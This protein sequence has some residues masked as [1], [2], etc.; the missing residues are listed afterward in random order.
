MLDIAAFANTFGEN[1]SQVVYA[2]S[3]EQ[4]L[5]SSEPTAYQ[6]AFYVTDNTLEIG[7]NQ[8]VAV[9]N[10]V[11]IDNVFLTYYGSDN[12]VNEM[13]DL[14]LRQ[15]LIDEIKKAVSLGAN[16]ADAQAIA[17]QDDLT[18][19]AIEEAVKELKVKEF[20]A[21]VTNYTD[22]QTSLLGN[23]TTENQAARTGQHWDGTDTS[24]YFEQRD[25]WGD[26]AWQMSMTQDVTLP[27]GD[28]VLKM[29][30]RSA[31]QAV[32]ATMSVDDENVRFPY[33]DDHGYGIST[34]GLTNFSPEATYANNGAGRG[35]EWRYIAFT[36]NEKTTVPIA[37][38]AICDQAVNQWASFSNISLL[39]K[40]VMPG[41]VN[42]DG[43]VD[44][45]DVTSLVNYLIDQTSQPFI[46]TAAD[47]SGDGEVT[48]SDLPLLVGLVLA[49]E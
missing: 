45:A 8:T 35:W 40:P 33:N 38:H 2:N 5:I 41:D 49:K 10:W 11:G 43:S 21:V 44:I 22:D 36:L 3:T 9:A 31:S 27:A 13:A 18:R 39:R 47:L 7:F 19:H 48:L 42:G 24:S 6:L 29:A 14:L 30:G 32:T 12:V 46:R 15:P 4:S 28:Y 26:Y 16:V 17:E 25:G 34:D 20:E 1:G 37:I 23:W